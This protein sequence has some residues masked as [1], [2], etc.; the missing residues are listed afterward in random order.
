[1]IHRGNAS[2]LTGLH[3]SL[4]DRDYRFAPVGGR[5]GRAWRV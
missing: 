5:G 1:M 2:V 4:R 3:A